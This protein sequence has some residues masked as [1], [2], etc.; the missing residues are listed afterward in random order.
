VEINTC[1]PTT[2]ARNDVADVDLLRKVLRA[3]IA[4]RQ[5]ELQHRALVD[6]K[7]AVFGNG[8]RNVRH[9]AANSNLSDV[10]PTLF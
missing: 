2:A 8:D 4:S 6:R 5:Q 3:L 10:F 9:Q 7:C 1:A